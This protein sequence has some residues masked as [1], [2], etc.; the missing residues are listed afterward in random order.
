MHR[1]MQIGMFILCAL[2]V[3]AVGCVSLEEVPYSKFSKAEAFKNPTLVYLNTVQ[4]VY[5]GMAE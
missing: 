2:S 5:T 3:L 1:N 4:S